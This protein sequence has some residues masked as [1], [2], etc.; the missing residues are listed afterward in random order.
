MYYSTKHENLKTIILYS[1][2][3][4]MSYFKIM[5]NKLMFKINRRIQKN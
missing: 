3:K 1:T 5:A 2:P 4:E